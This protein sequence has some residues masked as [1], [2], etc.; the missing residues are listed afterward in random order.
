MSK[1]EEQKTHRKENKRSHLRK[2]E[3]RQEERYAL[4]RRCCDDAHHASRCTDNAQVAA[5]AAVPGKGLGEQHDPDARICVRK[6]N[7]HFELTGELFCRSA[8]GGVVWRGERGS[9]ACPS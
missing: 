6:R 4:A 8:E 3:I 7:A 2:S 9:A 5:E 1:E